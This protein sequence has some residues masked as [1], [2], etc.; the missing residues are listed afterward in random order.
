[1]HRR[2][3]LAMTG[4][5]M[6]SGGVSAQSKPLRLVVPFPPGG[7]TDITARVLIEPLTRILGQPVMV[8]NRAGA[9]GS[10]GMSEVAKAAPDGLTLGVATLSTHGVN[11]AVY[12]KLPYDPIKDFAAVTEVVKAPGV[13]VV[14]PSLPVKDVAELVRYLK[15]HPGQ[16]SYATPG[17]GT[18][19]H[20]WGEL[21]KSSTGTFMVHIPYRGSGP[22]LNDV[23]GGQVLVYF[24]QVAASL[25]HIQS[26]KLR[27]LAVS[28]NKRLDMLPQVPTYAEVQLPT[29]NDPS[30]FGLVAPAAT[31]AATVHRLQ[32]A[33]AKA[34]REPAVRDRLAAQGLY[35]SGTTPEEFSVQI[36]REIEKMQTVSRFAK[37]NL[38]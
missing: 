26:G 32:E 36:R 11:P 7:A 31:P 19:G 20:M 8:E 5:A 18:I 37:I 33:V 6:L 12:K 10:I 2:Q 27:A 23:L 35:A 3:L 28:W 29:N 15:A 24:D 25:P 13:L 22:A 1:M 34:L 30:W 9:G 17:N 21:F 14:H 16:V 38:D 4:V